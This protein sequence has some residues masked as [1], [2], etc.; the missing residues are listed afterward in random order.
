MSSPTCRILAVTGLSVPS[1][2][3]PPSGAAEG[4]TTVTITGTN[5]ADAT[6]V[7]FGQ[8]PGAIVSNTDSQVVAIT[9]D[10]TQGGL[11]SGLGTGGRQ[12]RQPPTAPPR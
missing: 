10:A 5:L 7:D 11:Y 6:A 4:G 12:R 1:G 3:T 9:P 2:S 8:Y